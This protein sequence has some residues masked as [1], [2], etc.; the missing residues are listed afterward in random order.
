[1]ILTNYESSK[2]RIAS[3]DGLRFFLFLS[4]FLY[5]HFFS[6]LT[7]LSLALPFFICL[8]G[9]F[10]AQKLQ[11]S[12]YESVRT[13]LKIY[14]LNRFFR[15]APAYYITL[16][17]AYFFSSLLETKFHMFFLFNFRFYELTLDST[18]QFLSKLSVIPYS[19]GVHFWSLCVEIQF[20]LIAPI[21]LI[22]KRNY[23]IAISTVFVLASLFVQFWYTQNL[24]ASSYGTLPHFCAQYFLVGALAWHISQI[25]NAILLKN[26]ALKIAGLL[27]LLG[28]LGRFVNP[29]RHNPLNQF[30]PEMHQI[31]FILSFA[32]FILHLYFNP[33]N[34]I[35]T[36]LSAPTFVFL[37]QVS[38]S[39]Y[40]VHLFTWQI[41]NSILQN[42]YYSKGL[43]VILTFGLTLILGFALWFF[44]ERPSEIIKRKIVREIKNN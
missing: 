26:I 10:I 35:T 19:S 4:I 28:L 44:V 22:W 8:S 33:K 13:S 23:V 21:L 16:V 1:M 25:N 40:L 2:P 32:F 12:S 37:G 15:V 31:L 29:P 9:F 27:F 11:M 18:N 39:L 7:L 3:F 20:Y 34:I 42:F 43:L 6:E 30:S 24:P 5:H 41:S 36:I 38:Y 17:V 14:Y